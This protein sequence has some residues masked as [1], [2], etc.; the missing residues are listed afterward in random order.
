MLAFAGLLGAF[1][2]SAKSDP[3]GY[4]TYSLPMTVISLEVEAVQENF[5]AGPY[6]KYA[7][8][9]LGIKVKQEDFTNYTLSSVKMSSSVEADHSRRYSVNVVKGQMDLTFLKLT[10]CGLVSFADA[11]FTDEKM[12]RFS[13]EGD[14]DF[15]DKGVSSN[16]A[17]ESTTLYRNDKKESGYNRV[18]VQQS[19]V[20]EKSLEKKASETAAMILDLRQQ[21]LNILTGNTDAT[22]SGE[23]MGAA[24]A[25]L[26]KLE[27]EYMLL[28]VGYSE[29]S[30]QKMNF[31][32]IPQAGEVQRYIAFRLSETSGLMPSDNLSG[33]PVVME[34]V[35]Q[36]FDAPELP[37][38][39]G[40]EKKEVLAY[41]RIPAVCAVKLMD[42]VDI[43]LQSRVPVYQLGQESSLPVNIILN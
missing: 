22:Y 21:R 3:E 31:E 15:S 14:G 8:K 19:V 12:W 37:E 29:Y 39:K 38:S 16:L 2:L 13:V 43:L 27:K 42:G 28:F 5:Y 36:Q 6:A 11:R 10:S 40:K 20:V 7:E 23:A 4:V 9:Y 25:E 24:L 18:S 17:S 34:I 26:E 1:S 32:V 41:Y 35:P 30:T 33:K